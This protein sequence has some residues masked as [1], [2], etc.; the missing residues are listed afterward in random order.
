VFEEA[1]SGIKVVN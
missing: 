1:H